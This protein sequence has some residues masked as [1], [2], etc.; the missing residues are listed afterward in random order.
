LADGEAGVT[1]V[2]CPPDQ[3]YNW[4]PGYTAWGGYFLV[5]G[6][7]RCISFDIWASVRGRPEQITFPVG[8]MS[9]GRG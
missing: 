6:P 5:V 8:R 4:P 9:C 2:G 3:A 7:P 1:F